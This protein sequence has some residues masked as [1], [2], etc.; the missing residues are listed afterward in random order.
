MQIDFLFTNSYGMVFKTSCPSFP[1]SCYQAC[2]SVM[3]TIECVEY[4]CMYFLIRNK[5]LKLCLKRVKCREGNGKVLKNKQSE[6]VTQPVGHWLEFHLSRLTLAC[7]KRLLKKRTCRQDCCDCRSRSGT[8]HIL[9]QPTKSMYFYLK[10]AMPQREQKISG[11]D[12]K[13]KTINQLFK[14]VL[15]FQKK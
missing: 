14:S 6:F 13:Q 12:S 2:I 3:K 8:M 1:L 15:S 5:M 9:Y 10:M 7:C 4:M 11:R